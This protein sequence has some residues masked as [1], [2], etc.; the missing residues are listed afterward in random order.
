MRLW[1]WG[2]GP[3]EV[4]RGER[5]PLTGTFG[6]RKSFTLGGSPTREGVGEGE[7]SVEEGWPRAALTSEPLNPEHALLCTQASAREAITTAEI[8]QQRAGQ[9]PGQPEGQH[10]GRGSP[11]GEYFLAVCVLTSHRLGV[12]TLLGGNGS[13][14]QS[15]FPLKG[16]G[17]QVAGICPAVLSFLPLHAP[18]GALGD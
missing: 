13:L 2:G 1:G 8:E 9:A 4:G 10:R 18:H 3:E 6:P 16:H 11:E 17:R 5:V 12:A 15:R 7:V 14:G